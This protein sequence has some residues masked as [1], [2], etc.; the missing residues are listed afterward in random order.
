[1]KNSIKPKIWGPH[2]W[3]FLHYVSLGYPEKPTDKEKIY[4][5]NFYYSLQNVLPCEKCAQNYKKIL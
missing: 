4:Y 1:M 3:K 2:G 5:K